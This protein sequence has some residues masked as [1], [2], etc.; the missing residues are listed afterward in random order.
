MKS[1]K[2]PVHG[3]VEIPELCMKIIDTPEFQ[4]LRFLK[5]CGFVDYVYPVATHTRLEHSIG[6]CYL[7]GLLAKRLQEVHPEHKITSS[8]IL[9]VQVCALV[10]DLGHGPFSHSFERFIEKINSKK[11]IQIHF[12]H[13]EMSKE[14][15]KVLI[16]KSSFI[17]FC[18][19]QFYFG[20]FLFIIS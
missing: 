19:S 3:L 4:R 8:D 5:Q 12:N 9:Q 2:I 17:A 7:A 11:K 13:E 16:N 18:F 15:F 14:L 20:I 1:I 6:T 10:H